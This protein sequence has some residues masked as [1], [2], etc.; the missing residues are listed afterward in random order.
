[1]SRGKPVHEDIAIF[2]QEFLAEKAGIKEVVGPSVKIRYL[3]EQAAVRQ[4][5]ILR[6]DGTGSTGRGERVRV[7]VSEADRGGSAGVRTG[8]EPRF[9]IR[10]TANQRLAWERGAGGKGRGVFHG[11]RKEGA[12][13]VRSVCFL[14]M[15]CLL[16]FF[17][18]F[19]DFLER[20][21]EKWKSGWRKRRMET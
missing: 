4:L 20:L 3:V 12:R 9:Q 11:G 6:C 2:E 18:L 13:T 15:Y 17:F 16:Y 14:A 21:R 10:T 1:L 19:F 5:A 7:H 8:E